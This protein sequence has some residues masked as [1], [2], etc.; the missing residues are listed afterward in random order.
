MDELKRRVDTDYVYFAEVELLF[1]YGV[2]YPELILKL[3][4][5][6]YQEGLEDSIYVKKADRKLLQ[7][8]HTFLEYLENSDEPI[9]KDDESQPIEKWWWH[10]HKIA[11]GKYPSLKLKEYLR[12]IY[13]KRRKYW[14]EKDRY[15][16]KT[17]HLPLWRYPY[18]SLTG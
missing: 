13:R 16:T 12:D 14:K 3:R 2:G 7:K 8:V 5:K 15:T 1:N 6:V 4:E 17:N 9:T 10:L 11:K 18:H